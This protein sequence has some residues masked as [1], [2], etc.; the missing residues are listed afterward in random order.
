MVCLTTEMREAHA[1]LMQDQRVPLIFNYQIFILKRTPPK[2]KKL[3]QGQ[4]CVCLTQ[5]K[6]NV[7]H[8]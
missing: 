8:A 1:G 5:I 4:P 2:K 3:L 6:E 7:M